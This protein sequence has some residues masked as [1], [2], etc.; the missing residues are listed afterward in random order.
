M[1][2]MV[3]VA[4]PSRTKVLSSQVG[5]VDEKRWVVNMDGGHSESSVNLMS[6]HV[7]GTKGKLSTM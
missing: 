7:K 4:S 6:T 1:S 3:P 2:A 5:L